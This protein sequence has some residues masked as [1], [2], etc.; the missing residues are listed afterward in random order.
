MAFSHPATHW[1]RDS[2]ADTSRHPQTLCGHLALPTAPCHVVR[3]GN[4]VDFGY[5]SANWGRGGGL[6]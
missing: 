4:S 6:G 5:N 2:L 1:S 3:D